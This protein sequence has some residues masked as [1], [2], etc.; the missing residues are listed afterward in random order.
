[1]LDPNR[2]G[3]AGN[4]APFSKNLFTW[5]EELHDRRKTLVDQTNPHLHDPFPA[6]YTHTFSK[7]IAAPETYYYINPSKC[8]LTTDPNRVGQITVTP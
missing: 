6:F 2:T 7:V 3:L 1:M 5:S 4:P 8:S